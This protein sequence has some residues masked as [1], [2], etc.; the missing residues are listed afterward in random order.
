MP[1]KL[2]RGLNVSPVL[3]NDL[4][5]PDA[6]VDSSSSFP[7]YTPSK[8]NVSPQQKRGFSLRV[9]KCSSQ[10]RPP[11][12]FTVSKRGDHPRYSES[13]TADLLSDTRRSFLSIG[14]RSSQSKPPSRF[15]VPGCIDQPRCAD[16]R[17]A[18]LLSR[19]RRFLLQYLHQD[20][21]VHLHV[22]RL[23]YPE[24]AQPHS[25]RLNCSHYY[26]AVSL[27]ADSLQKVIRNLMQSRYMAVYHWLSS[28]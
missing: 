13:R 4:L 9:R 16:S 17:T 12:R 27:V 5:P 11:F 25:K 1:R 24:K 19:T 20:L 10:N 28:S 6:Q 14:R 23:L 15:T 8:L 3:I 18:D 26:F 21:R 22:H 2:K 7:C